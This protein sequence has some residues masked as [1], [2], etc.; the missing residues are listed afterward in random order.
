MKKIM[1]ILDIFEVE[2]KGVVIGGNN[3]DLDS[4][5][6]EEIS[7]YIGKFI[8][9]QS[10]TGSKIKTEVLNIEL[11]ESLTGAKS[12]FL[13]LPQNIKTF[14]DKDSTVVSF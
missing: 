3:S 10:L 2:G 14:I 8:E 1:Q 9:L 11:S 6:N 12:I 7:Q 13:L 4:M 5:S